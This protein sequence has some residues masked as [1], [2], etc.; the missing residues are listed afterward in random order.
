MKKISF[1]A[2]TFM[3]GLAVSAQTQ[4]SKP[5]PMAIQTR[6]GIKAG[7]NLSEFKIENEDNATTSFSTQNKG[8]YHGGVFVNI[9]LSSTFR[10]QPE[11]VYSMQGSKV[12][13][14]A[15]A[16]PSGTTKY[17]YD[18]KLGYLNLPI[19]VQYQTPGG[20]FVE[21]GPQI[22]YLLSAKNEGT[23]T[24][25]NTGEVDIKD[26]LDK[27]DIAWAGGIGYFSRI[28]LGV[29]ARYNFGLR[30]INEDNSNGSS[31]QGKIKNRVMQFG[32]FWQF[33][34]GK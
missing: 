27:T 2:L 9:P 19:M 22:G 12:S 5:T 23:G 10:V 28:G 18:S 3:T 33:G 25:N 26:N 24:N 7:A 32:L 34:A 29:S 4:T 30:D 8:G 15:P 21:T 20:F 11:L 14:T 17:T 16:V 13:A 1:I 6:F 31:N